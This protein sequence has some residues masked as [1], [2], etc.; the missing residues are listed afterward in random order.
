MA[1]PTIQQARDRA[2][3]FWDAARPEWVTSA[4]PLERLL[5]GARNGL[6]NVCS[7]SG[8]IGGVIEPRPTLASTLAK[9]LFFP[10]IGTTSV[11]Q[12]GYILFCLKTE[13]LKP[14]RVQDEGAAST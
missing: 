3:V 6:A 2:E 5:T 1:K 9:P 13:T 4:G 10:E 14:D 11:D 7:R 12:L 8:E